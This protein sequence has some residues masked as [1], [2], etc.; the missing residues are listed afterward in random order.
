MDIDQLK[1]QHQDFA[2]RA[3]RLREA[4]SA[5]LLALLSENSITLGVPIE[6]RFKTW[7][8]LA[9]KLDRKQISLKSIIDLQDLVGVR[10]ILLF[11]SDIKKVIQLIENSFEIISRE[12]TSNRLGDSEFGYQSQHYI[13]RL[14][15]NWLSV[16]TLSGLGDFTV[17]L[18]LRTLAQHIWAAASH[19]LQYKQESGVPRPLRRTINRVSALLEIVDL[20]FE[21]VLEERKAYLEDEPNREQ[22]NEPLNVDSVAMILGEVY[23]SINKKQDEPYADLLLDFSRLGVKTPEQLR[24]IITKHLKESLAADKARAKQEILNPTAILVL[25]NERLAKGVFFAHVGLARDALEREFGE[26]RA[27]KIFMTRVNASQGSGD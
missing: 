3:E 27:K 16:P 14:P 21:R 25:D 23:P 7:T 24:T 9:E 15:K 22:Q 6:S 4:I 18:Q 26:E 1:R 13:I 5:Q 8:S 20:E 11:S 19:K 10:I 2:G 12:D 17:E